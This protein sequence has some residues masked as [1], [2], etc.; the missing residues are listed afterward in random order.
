MACSLCR[1]IDGQRGRC[2]FQPVNPAEE[3][4]MREYRVRVYDDHYLVTDAT[5]GVGTF[6]VEMGELEKSLAVP[7]IG[8]A[9]TVPKKPRRK[10]GPN[11]PKPEAPEAP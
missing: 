10:R 4:P 6:P 1:T 3:V 7:A 11:K 5:V 8:I 2:V 9:A